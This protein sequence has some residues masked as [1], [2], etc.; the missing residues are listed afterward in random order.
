MSPGRARSQDVQQPILKRGVAPPS[1]GRPAA[2]LASF[3]LE[4]AAERTR[5]IAGYYTLLEYSVQ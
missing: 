4:G 1:A 5:G 3:V 2:S